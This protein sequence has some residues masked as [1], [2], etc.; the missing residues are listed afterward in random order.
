MST[1]SQNLKWF[2]FKVPGDLAYPIWIN[3]ERVIWVKYTNPGISTS[4]E[5]G[6]EQNPLTLEFGDPIVALNNYNKM[7]SIFNVIS[8]DKLSPQ[9]R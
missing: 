7:R 6:Y 3:F 5:I 2:E 8:I 1:N 9:P 4:I